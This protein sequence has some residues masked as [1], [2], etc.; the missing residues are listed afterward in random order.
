MRALPARIRVGR[1]TGMN[2]CNCRNKVRALQI[3]KKGAQ[4]SDKEHALI[5]DRP[6]GERYHIGVL[7][8]LLKQP[9]G[10]IELP[11]KG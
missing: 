8:G 2:H 4:L 3:G 6:A 11:V 7:R 9:P 10:N 1:E 5:Y